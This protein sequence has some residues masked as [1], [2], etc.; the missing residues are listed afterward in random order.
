MIVNYWQSFVWGQNHRP[1]MRVGIVR[2]PIPL[3]FRDY[4]F[5]KSL[6]VAQQPILDAWNPYAD[7]D[8]KGLINMVDM[9]KVAKDYQKKFNVTLFLKC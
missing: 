7:V 8:G 4:F 9:Y 3:T 6:N 5:Q 1:Q 2:M